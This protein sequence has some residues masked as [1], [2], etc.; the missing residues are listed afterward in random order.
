MTG[1]REQFEME[2]TVIGSLEWVVR[3]N[4]DRVVNVAHNGY[5]A[6]KVN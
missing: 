3:S 6:A 2:R 1:T 4:P 5:F